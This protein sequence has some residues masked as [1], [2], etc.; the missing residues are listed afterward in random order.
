MGVDTE[1]FKPLKKS[2]GVAELREKYSG[3]IILTVGRL[4][5]KNGQPIA[6]PLKAQGSQMLGGLADANLLIHFPADMTEISEGQ[7]VTV[8]ELQW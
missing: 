1:A 4:A 6:I 7:A 5:E 2:K 3:R 8:E